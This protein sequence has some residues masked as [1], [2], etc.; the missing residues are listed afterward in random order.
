MHR[1]LKHLD[2]LARNERIDKHR[3]ES[4][5]QDIE[6]ELDVRHA[7]ILPLVHRDD[8]ERIKQGRTHHQRKTSRAQLVVAVTLIEQAYTR[9]SQQNGERG[10]PR[11]LLM[12]EHRHQYR[13]HDGIDE[14]DG[15][16]NTCRHI[17]ETDIKR[18]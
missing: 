6:G 3:D 5:Y 12:E 10:G 15:A 1:S 17:M 11:H 8:I 13:R 14:E 9:Y 4:E 16:G 7:R 18:S 2:F